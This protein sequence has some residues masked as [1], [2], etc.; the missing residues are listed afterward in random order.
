[1]DPTVYKDLFQAPPQTRK[2]YN[3]IAKVA[4]DMAKYGIAKKDK[5]AAQGF[6]FRGIDAVLDALSPSLVNAGL[7]I[8]PRVLKQVRTETTTA[9]GTVQFGAIVTVAFD[10][11]AVEDGSQATVVFDGE[12][13]DSGD[14]ATSKAL[15][16]AYKYMAFQT[17]CIPVSGLDDSDADSPA[18][19]RA[20]AAVKPQAPANDVATDSGDTGWKGAPETSNADAILKEIAAASN[21]KELSALKIRVSEFNK[22]A[23]WKEIK[24]AY[25]ERNAALKE[26]A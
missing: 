4:V 2:V 7:I 19:T 20:K 10:L 5:N 17:F 15:S 26:A 16:M 22:D 21:A 9:K 25:T 24:A 11:I 23:R 14:K 8:L 12:A 6:S 18:E 13:K 1:M 3:A